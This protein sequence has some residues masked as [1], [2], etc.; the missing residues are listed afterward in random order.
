MN[1]KETV[2]FNIR[3][4]RELLKKL[5]ILAQA[6]DLTMSQLVRR[7]IREAWAKRAVQEGGMA[8]TILH[9]G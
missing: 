5:E 7:W 2:L 1:N 9:E 8:I 3:L 4:E 6:E